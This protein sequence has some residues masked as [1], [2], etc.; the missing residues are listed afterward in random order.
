[1]RIVSFEIN[2]VHSIG[3]RQMITKY[4]NIIIYTSKGPFEPQYLAIITD[5]L[6]REFPSCDVSGGQVGNS[7]IFTKENPHL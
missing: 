1:M 3:F 6:E 2:R 5:V 7:L 4:K